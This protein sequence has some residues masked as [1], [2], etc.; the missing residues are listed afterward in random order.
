MENYNEEYK[1]AVEETPNILGPRQSR[2]P[3]HKKLTKWMWRLFIVGGLSVVALFFFLS[4]ELPSFEQLENPKSR[5]ASEIYSS[6]GVLLGKFYVENRT[7]VSFDSIS[8]NVVNALIA[9]EDARFRKHSGIDPEALA[10]VVVKSLILQQSGAGGGSTISQQLAKLLVGR[11]N[12]KDKGTITKS[13]LMLK[14]K[15]KEWLTAVK[16]ERSYT[17]NEIITMYLN[18]FDFLYGANG[19]KSASEIYFNKKPSNLNINE[20]AMLVRML[21]NPSLYNP[22][23]DMKRAIKGREQVLKNMQLQGHIS[24]TEYHK[25]RVEEIDITTFRTKDHNDGLATHFRMYLR[26]YVK[27][28]LKSGKCEKKPDGTPYDIY[29]DGIKIYTTIDSRIQRHAEQSVW[30]HLSEHQE[31]LF[32]HWKDWNAKDPEVD[33]RGRNPWYYKNDYKTTDHELELRLL[34]LLRLVWNTE[35]Y[36]KMRTG[37]LP[38]ALKY[39]LRDIDIFRMEKVESYNKKPRAGKRYKEK[40]DGEALLKEWL[41]TGYATEKQVSQYRQVMGSKDWTKLKKEYKAIM[42]Y[43]KLPVEMKIFAYNNRRETDTLMSPFDSLRYLRMHL[44]AGTMAVEPQTG[45]V[46][47]W[48]GGIDHKYNQFDH[49]NKFRA[50]RQVGSSIKPFLY[51]LTIDLRGYSP[52]YKVWDVAT[53]IH[54]GEGRFDLIRDWTPKNA[55]AKYSGEEITLTEALRQSLNSISAKLM[56]DLGST[57][58]FREFLHDVGIDTSKV[59][60]SPTICLGTPDL[61]VQEMTGAYSIFAN[62]GIY[63]EPIFIDRIE[64]RNGNIIHNAAVH[65]KYKSV[66]TEQGAFVMNQMLQTV[67]RGASGFRGIK[68]PYGGKTGTTNFQADGWFMGITP[69]LVV[70]TWVGCDDRFI[71]FR[72]LTHGQGARMARPVFQ[73][74]IKYI[75]AD[76]SIAWNTS[77]QFPAPETIEREMDC[78]KYNQFAS[79]ADELEDFTD[80]DIYQDDFDDPNAKKKKEENPYKDDFD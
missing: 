6:D 34:A 27:D 17:K 32:E 3:Q 48:V 42:D 1:K 22:K 71:R 59:P 78:L 23:R 50:G 70:G 31:K 66:L 35:R 19:I 62:K 75:E 69:D 56:K 28:L 11:P 15:L 54:K 68:T 44:Q 25:L 9:T 14:T 24:E 21:K 20:S 80:G 43:M 16:L 12:T 47:A 65:Q 30:D 53:T 58:K 79:R 39:K 18:E 51:A 52:C 38:T 55:N 36:Q 40:L 2:V 33:M 37:M 77:V 5:I 63:T 29:R 61:S 26:D 45:H 67:Q 13:W 46:K 57:I 8:P 41:D 10:R 4:F 7:P 74:L 73:N 49:V 64:T 60:N 72:S 76:P